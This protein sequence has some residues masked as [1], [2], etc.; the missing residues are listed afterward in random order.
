[1]PPRYRRRAAAAAT[2][3]VAEDR[4]AAERG[5]RRAPT[6]E[7]GSTGTAAAE[8]S[9]CAGVNGATAVGGPFAASGDR[10]ARPGVALTAR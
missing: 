10:G 2:G 8:R 4:V 5:D 6:P 7:G 9:R 3:A 1:M